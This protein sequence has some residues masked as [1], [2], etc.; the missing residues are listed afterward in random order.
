MLYHLV[1]VAAY[2]M[3]AIVIGRQLPSFVPDIAPLT[4]YWIGGC[5]FLICALAH[6]F[7]M[8]RVERMEMQKELRTIKRD[9]SAAEGGLERFEGILGGL[10]GDDQNMDGFASEMKMLRKLLNQ[11]TLEMNKGQEG[12]TSASKTNG[13]TPPTAKE[14]PVLV[15]SPE[16]EDEEQTA[17]KRSEILEIVRSG[18]QENRVDLYLQPIVRLPQR[19][20]KFYEAF[21]RIRGPQG[22][23]ITPRQYLAIAEE[24]GLVGTIDNLLLIR[25]VQLIRRVRQKSTDVGFF[26]NVSARTMRDASFFHQFVEFLDR[27]SDLNENLILEFAQE[28]IDSATDQVRDG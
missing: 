12:A 24:A 3:T 23:I 4:G 21:S 11:L 20:A 15:A 28:D 16:V 26:V 6:E 8:R 9:L 10:A 27:N 2:V 22:E 18:L 17:Q 1:I 5:F 13:A 25:C 14:R 19:R 7:I